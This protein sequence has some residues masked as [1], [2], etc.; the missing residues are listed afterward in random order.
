MQDL[1]PPPGH[2]HLSNSQQSERYYDVY[3]AYGNSPKPSHKSP[4]QSHLAY[5]EK[6]RQGKVIKSYIP[7]ADDELRLDIGDL[8]QTDKIF[9]DGWGI[10][11]NL[12]SGEFGAFPMACLGHNSSDKKKRAS[13][14]FYDR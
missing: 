7:M 12:T 9:D 3:S 11:V 4:A 5:K 1:R 10:G 6:P 2:A 13:S 8:I 14:L